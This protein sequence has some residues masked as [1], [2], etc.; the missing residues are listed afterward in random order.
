[1]ACASWQPASVDEDFPRN[2]TTY[3]WPT[4]GQARSFSAKSKPESELGTAERNQF[5]IRR[6]LDQAPCC[7]T[8]D[9]VVE[10]RAML[11][12]IIAAWRPNCETANVV[13]TMRSQ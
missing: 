5:I 2:V 12:G 6:D 11:G 10:T 8:A 3:G 4:L 9:A 1:M 7:T 13:L